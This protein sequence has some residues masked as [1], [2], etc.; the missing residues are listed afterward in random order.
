ML[1]V[2]TS[3][4]KKQIDCKIQV[5]IDGCTKVAKKGLTTRILEL[6]QEI[7]DK[8]ARLFRTNT[9]PMDICENEKLIE[10][11]QHKWIPRTSK[12]SR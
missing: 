9:T 4:L 11:Y 8:E 1:V 2:N 10:E 7:T 5:Q 12:R 3:A 6:E